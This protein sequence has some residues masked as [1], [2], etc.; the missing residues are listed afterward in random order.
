MAAHKITGC[1]AIHSVFLRYR[2]RRDVNCDSVPFVWSKCPMSPEQYNLFI[3][4]TEKTA[5]TR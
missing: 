2:V 4:I 3:N 5:V 1:E